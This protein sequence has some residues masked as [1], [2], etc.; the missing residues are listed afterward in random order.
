MKEALKSIADLDPWT[1]QAKTQST[2]IRLYI[3]SQ[4]LKTHVTVH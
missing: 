1:L 2:V 4:I 3:V